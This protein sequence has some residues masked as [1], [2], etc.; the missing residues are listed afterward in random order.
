M[1]ARR[2]RMCT[3]FIVLLLAVCAPLARPSQSQTA[4]PNNA[5]SIPTLKTKVRLVLVDVVVTN[6]R[7]EPIPGLHKADF[8]ISEDGTP[9]TISTFEEHHGAPA[10]Q[11][12]LPQ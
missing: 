11:V 7:G 1:S 9:Q 2:C 5:S 6:N 10:T 4:A 8:E 3:R 12:K